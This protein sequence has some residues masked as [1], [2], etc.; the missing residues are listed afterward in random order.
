M[1]LL[2]LALL[3]PGHDYQSVWECH[4]PVDVYIYNDD[5]SMMRRIRTLNLPYK[6]D[7]VTERNSDSS[8]L[9]FTSFV[10]MIPKPTK[11]SSPSIAYSTYLSSPLVSTPLPSFILNAGCYGVVVYFVCSVITIYVAKSLLILAIIEFI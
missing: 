9:P 10:I 2:V 5:H 11:P 8:A 6:V 4:I 7:P 1:R 3:R